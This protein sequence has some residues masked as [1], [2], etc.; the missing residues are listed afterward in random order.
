MTIGFGCDKMSLNSLYW[1]IDAPITHPFCT[2]KRA[3]KIAL[4]KVP[5][6]LLPT[7]LY[8][9]LIK[10]TIYYEYNNNYFCCKGE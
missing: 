9:V 7:S 8:I 2:R 1:D 5:P 4:L 6:V 3:V 10:Y